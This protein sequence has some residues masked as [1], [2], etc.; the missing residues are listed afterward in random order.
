MAVKRENNN[1]NNIN[2][3]NHD[4][5]EEEG[6]KKDNAETGEKVLEKNK[7]KVRYQQNLKRTIMGG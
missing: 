3:Y 2:N 6:K 5:K 4:N 1:N 7:C